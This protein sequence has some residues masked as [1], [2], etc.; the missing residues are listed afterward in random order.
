[1]HKKAV[2]II[3]AHITSNP[4]YDSYP[5]YWSWQDN[6]RCFMNILLN[7]RLVLEPLITERLSWEKSAE[8]YRRILEWDTKMIFSVI[9]WGQN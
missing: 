8:L 9:N 2:T 7:K 5:G 1:V 6:A 4:Q 3:G